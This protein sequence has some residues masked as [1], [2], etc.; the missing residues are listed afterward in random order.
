MSAPDPAP[1]QQAGETAANF[2]FRLQDW[3]YRNGTGGTGP[4]VAMAATWR[5]QQF[6]TDPTLGGIEVK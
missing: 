5:G 2:S 1:V 3:N 4:A 6:I